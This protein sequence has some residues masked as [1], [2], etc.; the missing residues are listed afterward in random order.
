MAADS[1]GAPR[2]IVTRA[3]A[4]KNGLVRY[5]TGR[6]CSQGHVA[7]RYTC[8]NTCTACQTRTVVAWQDRNP[9]RVAEWQRQSQKR[10]LAEKPERV[11]AIKTN[12]RQ[13]NRDSLKQK[14]LEYYQSNTDR[15]RDA[16]RRYR[17]E[18]PWVAAENQ[19]AREAAKLKATPPWADRDAIR[20]VY[21][22][23]AELTR[24]T[25]IL[26]TVDHIYPLKGKTSC[27]LHVHWNLQ[28]LTNEENCSKGNKMPDEW[29]RK[30]D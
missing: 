25:G 11:K 15:Y 16:K 13:A 22:K 17:K 3:D 21:R 6:Q 1:I 24:Q 9:N 5:F 4:K 20:E 8:N 18:K 14:S 19:R 12:Y 7:E 29:R 30:S 28:I 26:H 10:F 2:K 23:A 27:G